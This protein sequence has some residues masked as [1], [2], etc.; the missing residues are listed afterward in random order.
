MKT[1]NKYLITVFATLILLT[2]SPTQ[3]VQAETR[4]ISDNQIAEQ[5][6]VILVSIVELLQ[7]NLKLVQMGLIR[8]L[9]AQVIYLQS[10]R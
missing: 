9:E 8:K 10:R 6:K 2:S 4:L 1:I 3:S 7:E 5:K